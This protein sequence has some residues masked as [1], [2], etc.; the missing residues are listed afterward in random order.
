MKRRAFLGGI[1]FSLGH[2][3]ASNAN[4]AAAAAQIEPLDLVGLYTPVIYLHSQEQ[5]FPEDPMAFIRASRFRHHK[6]M[7]PDQGWD[8]TSKRFVTSDSHAARFYNIH[9]RT[10]NSYRLHRNGENRRP[11]DDNSGHDTDVF[12]QPRG[13]RRGNRRLQNVPV[14]YRLV[15]VRG[16]RDIDFVIQYWYFF[17]YSQSPVTFGRLGSF[18]HQGDWE[19]VDI[20]FKGKKPVMVY[21][22]AHGKVK[23]LKYSSIGKTRDGKVIAFA[24]KGTHGI[25]PKKGTHT[26]KVRV[27]GVTYT[28]QDVT[29][30]GFLWDGTKTLANLTE[31]AWK[32]F[33]GA[34][35]EVGTFSGTTGPLGPYLKTTPNY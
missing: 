27:V 8:K 17:G 10:I 9:I 18:A 16:R 12:L 7:E 19:H 2:C 1:V 31:Q 11:R 22:F 34:W 25:Y 26:V 33:A 23:K 14:F 13:A 20:G 6:R 24:A 30:A 15:K 21:C 35:G 5:Y 28:F 3:I 32:D 29:N 4:A